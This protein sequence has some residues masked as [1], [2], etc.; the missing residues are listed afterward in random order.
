MQTPFEDKT[1][2]PY[3]RDKAGR[4]AKVAGQNSI[5]KKGFLQNP[6]A[7]QC[8]VG[9]WPALKK[10]EQETYLVT[11][12]M[13]T[14]PPGGWEAALREWD[15]L[16][17]AKTSLNFS[18]AVKNEKRRPWAPVHEASMHEANDALLKQVSV[19]N[20]PDILGKIV[21]DK[22]LE[23]EIHT[24]VPAGITIKWDKVKLAI[25]TGILPCLLATGQYLH[26]VIQNKDHAQTLPAQT[27]ITTATSPRIA[28][29]DRNTSEEKSTLKARPWRPLAE[30]FQ[31]T[32]EP[33]Q[34][35]VE[36]A[37]PEPRGWKIYSVNGT[38]IALNPEIEDIFRA[39]AKKSRISFNVLLAT[40]M[41]E[42]G[43]RPDAVNPKTKAVGLFQFMTNKTQTL[44]EVLYKF[45]AEN[46]YADEANLVEEYIK[47]RDKHGR[48]I[49]GY[50]PVNKEAG[51]KIFELA[52][53]PEFNTAMFVAY[54]TPK[55]EIFE[56][57]MGRRITDGE[58]I[59]LNNIGLEGK[60]GLIAFVQ[61]AEAEKNGG[62]KTL[63]KTF[64]GKA[65]SAQNPSL[66]TKDNKKTTVGESYESI[67]ALVGGNADF[68]SAAEPTAEF[69]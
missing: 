39:Q 47:R 17:E 49:L 64:L 12:N 53:D 15:A 25:A 69:R 21:L 5:A 48:A 30:T 59:L 57:V 46:G 24:E 35:I 7:I 55:L 14:R 28:L 19:F 50:R 45:G 63:A 58:I 16:E 23:Q 33:V 34:P 37:Q 6:R 65:I 31:P 36:T 61:Q 8:P 1:K 3:I 43:I 68:A 13:I 11:R 41:R 66:V 42:S 67:M 38:R 52:K 56:K 26:D 9:G 4:F 29:S 32:V 20:T 18:G 22:D 40:S 10:P 54:T 51:K 60:R 44:Y 62:R 2:D 27:H